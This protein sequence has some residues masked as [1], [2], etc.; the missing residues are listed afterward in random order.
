M[1]RTLLLTAMIWLT[2]AG[3]SLANPAGPGDP[4]PVRE[5]I[6]F[7]K[8]GDADWLVIKEGVQIT[9]ADLLRSYKADL[10]LSA[11]YELVPYRTDHEWV[12]PTTGISS[13]T[14]V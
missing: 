10:G 1:I 5:R 13:I 8:N 14:G 7:A 9:A 3:F 6:F 11:Q 12:F 4:L 2:A